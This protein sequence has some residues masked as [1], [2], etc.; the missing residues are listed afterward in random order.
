MRL[1]NGYGGISKLSGNRRRPFVA[2]VTDT[3]TDDG[4]QVYK[5]LGYFATKK[6]ALAELVKYNQ[7]EYNID[8]RKL[9]FEQI[10]KNWSDSHFKD[11]SESGINGY[12]MAYKKCHRLYKMRFADIRAVH[13]QRTIDEDCET[14]STR[15][16]VRVLYNVLYKYA[17][18]NDIVEKMY[19]KSVKI[20]KAVT[21]HEKKILSDE[22]V[23]MLWDNV[24]KID[25]VDTI[26]ILIYTGLR[27]SELLE[28]ENKNVHI[29]EQ[30]MIRWKEDV[31][32][33]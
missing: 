7:T 2:R 8:Q 22:Q 9:T 1:P 11:I 29:D 23:R 32:T 31:C 20:G 30:Y 6:E 15:Q 12:K 13:L 14:Y 19:N 25:G 16:K 26:L 27:I 28:I 4:V 3:Y 18:D 5:T 17:Y 21:V 24:D 10:Y 33:A